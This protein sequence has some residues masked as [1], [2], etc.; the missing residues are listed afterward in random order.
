MGNVC[1][2]IADA[3]APS[4][5]A[6]APAAAGAA[7]PP[8]AK[9]AVAPAAAAPVVASPA[10]E[11]ATAAA[12]VSAKKTRIFIVFYSMYGHIKT[13]AET[14]AE[15]AKTVDGVE[16]TIY[17]VWCNRSR[18]TMPRSSVH[19]HDAA[20]RRMAHMRRRR[21]PMPMQASLRLTPTH[22]YKP[23]PTQAIRHV[24][25]PGTCTCPLPDLICIAR[26]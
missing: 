5:K 24:R 15:A 25:V 13:M 11:E 18:S 3:D 6:P 1:G 7:A 19:H 26:P 2:N 12:T 9:P 22:A 20:K 17:Q 14:M 23:Y 16:V 4:A 8:A 21:L 10:A